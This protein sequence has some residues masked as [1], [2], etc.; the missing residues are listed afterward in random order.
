VVL[1]DEFDHFWQTFGDINVSIDSLTLD[2]PYRTPKQN[3]WLKLTNRLV[4]EV[5]STSSVQEPFILSRCQGQKYFSSSITIT[6]WSQ[7]CL[8]RRNRQQRGIFL[9]WVGVY[10]R[11]LTRF[12]SMTSFFLASL[13]MLNHF[14]SF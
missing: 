10:L 6:F 3:F 11:I 7:K 1:H 2:S 4:S 9:S 13:H 5:F 8:R 14:H 12:L